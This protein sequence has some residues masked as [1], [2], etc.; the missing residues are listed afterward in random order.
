MSVLVVVLTIGFVA[1]LTR[2]LTADQISYPIRQ[3]IVVRL[4][5]DHPVS[6]LVTCAWCVGLW[7]S[8][9]VGIAA[10][11]WAGERW[12]LIAG[13]IGTGAYVTGVLADLEGD[14]E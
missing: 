14:R 4:G 1:R 3:R 10:Y 6:Y 11:W 5:P 7:V 12:W 2:L 8:I 9:G 13:L